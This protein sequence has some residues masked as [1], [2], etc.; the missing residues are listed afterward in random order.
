MVVDHG[1][2]GVVHDYPSLR[3]HAR[4][5]RLRR[6]S[7][8]GPVRNASVST[9]LTHVIRNLYLSVVSISYNKTK[10]S[11]Q[12]F[13]RKMGY[14]KKRVATFSS[15]YDAEYPHPKTRLRMPRTRVFHK[16]E[17]P[18]VVRLIVIHPTLDVLPHVRLRS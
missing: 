6:I 8:F 18:S 15:S 11:C 2:V 9:K 5:R 7:P 10:S 1:S 13:F 16:T 12:P 4:E 3:S 14:F 17:A